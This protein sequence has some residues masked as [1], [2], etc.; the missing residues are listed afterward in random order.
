M[1]TP[2]ITDAELEEWE[3]QLTDQEWSQSTRTVVSRLTKALRAC[4]QQSKA[5]DAVVEAMIQGRPSIRAF[6]NYFNP[7]TLGE[8]KGRQWIATSEMLDRID[9]KL[10]ALDKEVG[11][12]SSK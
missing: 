6:L 12:A 5:K 7:G 2:E 1:V 11:D 9:E 8:D 4:H 10:A 3:R